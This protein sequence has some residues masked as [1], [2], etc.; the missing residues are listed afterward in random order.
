MDN[1]DSPVT[2]C[3]SSIFSNCHIEIIRVTTFYDSVTAFLHFFTYGLFLRAGRTGN[4]VK[5]I[6]LHVAYTFGKHCHRCH[7]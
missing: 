4:R 7:K 3:D 2:V 6:I 1:R 5:G